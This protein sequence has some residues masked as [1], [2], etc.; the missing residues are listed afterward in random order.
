M[1]KTLL[2]PLLFLFLCISAAAQTITVKDA[3]TNAPISDVYIYCHCASAVSNKKGEV[4]LE[5]LKCCNQLNFQ[6]P[7]FLFTSLNLQQL[8][9]LDYLIYMQE[10]HMG[11]KEIEL[12]FNKWEANSKEVPIEIARIGKKQITLNNPQTAADLLGASGEVF[13][14]KSQ[15]GGGSPMIRGLST[16]RVLLVVDG[17]RMNTA[18]FREGNVQNVISLDP[19]IV[20]SAEIVFGPGS[21]IYGSDALGGVMDFHTL[22][23]KYRLGNQDKLSIDYLLRT[24]SANFEKTAHG[25]LNYGN[26][27]WAALT[28]FTFS[29]YDDLMMGS[30]GPDS[31]LRNHYQKRTDGEDMTILN[32]NPRLQLGSAYNQWNL[33]QKL[34]FRPV[35]NLD[36]NYGFHYS[37]TSD[38][39]RYDRLIQYSGEDTL[40][41]S[42][43]F[44]GPQTW[45]MHNLGMTLDRSNYFFDRFKSTIAYQ[46]FEESRNDRRMFSNNLRSRTENVHAYSASFDFEKR[47]KT[48]TNLYY[49]LEYV[50]NRVH[51]E[52][53]QRD[54]VTGTEQRIASRY[55]DNSSW[56]YGAAY[57]SLKH[58]LGPKV[59]FN[60]GIRAN[61]VM[62]KG[63]IDD[64]FFA[65]D[66]NN[67]DN[68]FFAI[69][70]S[71]GISYLYDETLQVRFNLSNGFRA[72][73]I[74]D[75]AKVFDS[76]PGNVV[77]PNPDLGA[78]HLYT[79]DIGFIKTV[80]GSFQF[81][82]SAYYSLLD[83]A[84]VRRDFTVNGQ[85][86]IM[87][88]GQESDVKALQNAEQANIYGMQTA[89]MVP[90]SSF[91]KL[92]SSLHLNRG[93]TTAGEP[94]R[95]VAPLFGS[96]HLLM[97]FRKFGAELNVRY[98]GA[99]DYDQLAPSE[100][101]KPFLYTS[102]SQGN[103]YSPEW[104]TVNA[105]FNY[106]FLPQLEL[107]LAVENIF[108]RRYRPYSSGIAAPGRNF[109]LALR[110]T[111]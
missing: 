96:T 3:Q 32:P 103:P 97:E 45:M 12:S 33:M 69:N 64:E 50:F 68:N 75:A 90:L 108:D 70:G 60:S 101:D 1:S 63:T 54:I 105:R 5:K 14:Q 28:S 9:T 29:D 55:P 88:D 98:N 20:N 71:V 52:G 31:Y 30:F 61:Y 76:E 111:I 47:L 15:L 22:E 94:L 65:F 41:N 109:I 66:F 16:N 27:K 36:L 99:I 39:P 72:P 62:L 73:N 48:N 49:G 78:E 21:V 11:L 86:T 79:A 91:L 106:K 37:S 102:D 104:G 92:R 7:A 23:A 8:E 42:E 46:F 58:Y 10:S 80:K 53:F 38:V 57:A 25:H 82:F 26:E 67:I 83:N 110:G 34:R 40:R 93:E 100:R 74:D 84:I 6:H 51:S 17:V 35:Q 13:I 107:Q 95:H 87:Y 18:I 19:N 89:I 81:E 24:S 4:Q 43:W 77:V 44:Y 2:F 56:Q 85:S 59:V